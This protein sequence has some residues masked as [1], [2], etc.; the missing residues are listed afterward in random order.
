MVLEIIEI[1]LLTYLPAKNGRGINNL[2]L[3][4]S[5]NNFFKISFKER[6]SGPTHSIILEYIFLEIT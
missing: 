6:T 2:F 1:F 3:L 5:F 4:I